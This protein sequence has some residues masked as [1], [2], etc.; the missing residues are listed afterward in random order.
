MSE[1]EEIE[2]NQ[3][4]LWLQ[5]DGGIPKSVENVW[6]TAGL[7]QRFDDAVKKLTT[8]EEAGSETVEMDSED[9]FKAE[10]GFVDVL[11]LLL[12][13]LVR[14]IAFNTL[15]QFRGC[16]MGRAIC[17]P[18]TSSD[19][20]QNTTL[21]DVLPGAATSMVTEVVI[22]LGNRRFDGGANSRGTANGLVDVDEEQG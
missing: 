17:S 20:C 13:S 6:V 22:A 8:V 4:H 14:K 21:D 9:V 19:T 3:N 15:K 11:H 18:G 10:A 5:D 2:C 16:R 12:Q 1:V 7:N